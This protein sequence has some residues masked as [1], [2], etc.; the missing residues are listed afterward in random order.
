MKYLYLL[1][2]IVLIIF[3]SCNEKTQAIID[4]ISFKALFTKSDQINIKLYDSIDAQQISKNV[5]FLTSKKIVII[6]KNHIQDFENIF[7]NSEKTDYC[8]CPIS[9]YSISFLKNNKQHFIFYV[10][11]IEFI[12]KIRIYE[13]NYQ[14]SYIIQKKYWNNFL[15]KIEN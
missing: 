7:E 4:D 1:L 5:K 13:T 9:N 12:N 14:Y 10:D 11:T 2:I 15:N 3:C 6:T 8:C